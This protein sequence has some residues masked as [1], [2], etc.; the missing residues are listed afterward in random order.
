MRLLQYHSYVDR[1]GF[2]AEGHHFVLPVN[3]L[4]EN[5]RIYSCTNAGTKLS[6]LAGVPT[7]CM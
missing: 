7:S 1:G 3:Y 4:A 6:A 5:D 2:M